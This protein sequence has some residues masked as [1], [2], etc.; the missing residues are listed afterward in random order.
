MDL[1]KLAS[2]IDERI[3]AK[4]D[5]ISKYIEKN[6]A[7]SL[8]RN[9]VELFRSDCS[10]KPKDA[11]TGKHDETS[12]LKFLDVYTGEL[13]DEIEYDCIDCSEII[14]NDITECLWAIER[15]IIMDEIK[16]TDISELHEIIRKGT[17]FSEHT[18]KK[19]FETKFKDNLE[20]ICFE[21]ADILDDTTL[22][23]AGNFYD[24]VEKLPIYM[25]NPLLGDII[26]RNMDDVVRICDNNTLVDDHMKMYITNLKRNCPSTKEF[27]RE[28][29]KD[30]VLTREKKNAGLLK[31]FRQSF[32]QDEIG[33]I[34]YFEPWHFSNRLRDELVS[35]IVCKIYAER[36]EIAEQYQLQFVFEP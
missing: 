35:D 23:G 20:V 8:A 32:S 25:E 3:I 36:K 10:N 4:L 18:T 5:D 28:R 12:L 29:W 1:K 6:I 15:N 19:A 13:S 21:I 14:Y 31:N 27:F 11:N 17:K 26:A 22:A 24:V 2:R 16:K 9:D 33:L 30:K 7:Y 34:A